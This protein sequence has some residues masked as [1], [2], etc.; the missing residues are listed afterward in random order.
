MKFGHLQKGGFIEGFSEGRKNF[1]VRLP[2]KWYQS[3][4][5]DELSIFVKKGFFVSFQIKKLWPFEDPIPSIYKRAVRFSLR[6]RRE[7]RE[8]ME[9]REGTPFEVI[10]PRG[11]FLW[12]MAKIK[13][14]LFLLKLKREGGIFGK[15]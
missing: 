11:I 1:F 15:I 8:G 6:R 7:G 10:F 5:L 13:L 4:R 14:F 12:E 2:W 9:G 3:T